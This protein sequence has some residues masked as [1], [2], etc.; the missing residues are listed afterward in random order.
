M[1]RLLKSFAYAWQGIK[2]CIAHEQNFKIHIAAGAFVI[3][4][5]AILKCTA[6]EWMILC[7]S[8]AMV[9]CAELLNTAIE[10]YC[11]MQQKSFNPQIKTIKDTAA[12]AVLVAALVAAVCGAVIFVPK[13]LQ[14]F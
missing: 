13:L 10:K 2:Y 7:M 4:F 1:N 14:L 11:D 6:V 8:I 3:A 12:G 9:L 5:A